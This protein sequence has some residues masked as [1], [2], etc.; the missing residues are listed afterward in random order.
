MTPT[1]GRVLKHLSA[2]RKEVVAAR[3]QPRTARARGVDAAGPRVGAPHAAPV[4]SAVAGRED[5]G[6]VV[7]A[8]RVAQKPAMRPVG[9]GDLPHPVPGAEAADLPGPAGAAVRRLPEAAAVADDPA[10]RRVDEVAVH[11]ALV[12]GQVQ[13]RPRVAAIRRP[14][15]GAIARGDPAVR[16]IDEAG[17]VKGIAEGLGRGLVEPRS[18]AVVGGEHG[19]A[20]GP[21]VLAVDEAH[22]PQVGVA[23]G[24]LHGPGGAG[25]AAVQHKAAIADRPDVSGGRERHVGHPGHAACGLRHLPEPA[26]GAVGHERRGRSGQ[27]RE[28]YERPQYDADE[29]STALHHDPFAR[30]I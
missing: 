28:Q 26:V 14:E 30:A 29:H 13:A 6:V 23:A 27:A 22:R 24:G 7:L 16:R 20:A 2:P 12:A 25:V 10:V 8:C 17:I 4:R 1:V 9:E 19:V 21:A 5:D 3:D 11:V 18:A 15:D